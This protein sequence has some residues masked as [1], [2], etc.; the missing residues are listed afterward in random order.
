MS[1]DLS[2]LARLC[3]REIGTIAKSVHKS[4]ARNA[5]E[6]LR[7]ALGLIDSASRLKEWEIN[8]TRSGL[9]YNLGAT[10][11]QDFVTHVIG[12][13][14]LSLALQVDPM[15]WYPN[16][17]KS[18]AALASRQC[19]KIMTEREVLTCYRS[20]KERIERICH[21]NRGVFSVRLS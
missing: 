1:I 9:H 4:W 6:Q 15:Y 21:D 12:P 14:L 7:L 16:S 10:D 11:G 13:L 3:A 20:N 18:I 19:Q 8:L 2:P 17:S 5:D